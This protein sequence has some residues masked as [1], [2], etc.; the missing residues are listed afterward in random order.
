MLY[1]VPTLI[2][3]ILE[4]H[5]YTYNIHHAANVSNKAKR[6][7]DTCAEMCS[8]SVVRSDHPSIHSPKSSVCSA[9]RQRR[10]NSLC[11]LK[12]FSKHACSPRA[13]DVLTERERTDCSQIVPNNNNKIK[14]GIAQKCVRK[15][16][17]SVFSESV[18]QCTVL[19]ST[20]DT[21]IY[22]FRLQ[23]TFSLYSMYGAFGSL[24]TKLHEFVENASFT[25]IR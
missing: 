8:P 25:C 18:S 15:Y 11:R 19:R 6:M 4:L 23:T 7:C 10:E 9:K 24:G 21:N 2:Y 3:N 16:F 22:K 17:P 20:P 13:A 1:G 12:Y 14:N 5:C